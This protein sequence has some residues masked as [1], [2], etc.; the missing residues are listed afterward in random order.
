MSRLFVPALILLAAAGCKTVS[1]APQPMGDSARYQ[2]VF[3]GMWTAKTHPLEYPKAGAF[4]GPHFSGL[5]GAT[6]HAGYALFKEGTQP[7]PG[8]ERLSE[9]GKH[10][11][12]DQEIRAAIDSGAAGALFETGPLRDTSGSI[13]TTVRVGAAHSLV[14][15]VAMIAPSPDWFTGASDVELRENGR[16]VD[17]KEVILYA[18]DS[19]GDDGT[20]Y[21]AP[22]LDTN[23][24]K[25][26]ALN[27]SHHFVK[28]G[29]RVP[30]A[31]LTFKNLSMTGMAEAR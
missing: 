6:H 12:L 10:G 27:D 2:I 4:S 25:P 5:I 28:M 19:G 8:L 17:S 29:K 18:W 3:S 15:A 14:S 22:D 24:K 23:P 20:T 31:K 30:V 1:S 26:T 21:E 13:E 9:E 7:S 11:P 16:W